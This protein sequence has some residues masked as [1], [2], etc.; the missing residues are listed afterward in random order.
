MNEQMNASMNEW[1]SQSSYSPV[2]VLLILI[3]I[4]WSLGEEEETFF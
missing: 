1:S 3:N 2:I 4:A